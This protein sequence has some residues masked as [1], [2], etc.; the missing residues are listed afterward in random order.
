MPLAAQ[1]SVYP[2]RQP[3]LS[4]AIEQTLEIFQ[5]HGLKVEPEAMSSVVL[6][7]EEEVF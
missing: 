5:K 4:Q 6:G 1:V 2:L 7:S 3:H